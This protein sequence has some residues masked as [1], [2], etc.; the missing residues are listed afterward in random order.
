MLFHHSRHVGPGREAEVKYLARKYRLLN[1]RAIHQRCPSVTTDLTSAA[2]QIYI[3]SIYAFLCCN[4]Q[5]TLHVSLLDPKL[6]FEKWYDLRLIYPPRTVR[7]VHTVHDNT[8][9]YVPA[10]FYKQASQLQLLLID[11]K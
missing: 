7:T 8:A 3:L 6:K 11:T 4:G 1:L 2:P 5:A 10:Q 9:A